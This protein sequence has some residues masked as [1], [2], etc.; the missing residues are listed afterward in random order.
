V[1]AR[2]RGQVLVIFAGGLVAL[3]AI[4]ALVIDLGF[5]FMIRRQEQNA[6]DPGAVAAARFIR[7]SATPDLVG[8][9]RAACFYARTNGFFR[10]ATT[11]DGCIP[12]N[13]DHGT[14]LTVN[15]PPSSSGGTYAGRTGFVEVVLA[16]QHQTFLGRVIG[17]S[18]IGVATSAVGAYS[19]GDSNTSSL[20]A[21]DP[22]GSCGSTTGGRTHGTGD[23]LIH[24]V[25][26]VTSGGYVHVNSTCGTATKDTLCLNDSQGALTVGGTS[27]LT[28]PHT[29][30]SGTCKSN[31]SGLFGTLTEGAVQIGDPLLELPPPRLSDY[32]AGQCGPTGIVT[33]PTGPN[34]GGCVFKDD[35]VVPL[36][37]GV[38]Y[39]G[40]NIQ[41][42]G[43]T[44]ELAPG[45]YILA[46]GGIKLT[47]G[48]SI[49][50]VQGGGV[51]VPAPVMIFNTD[52]PATNSGQANID[53]NATATLALRALDSGPY[54]GIVVWNDGNGSNPG[55]LID[56]KGQSSLN[57]SG[58]IYSPKGHVN[59]EGGSSGTS[60]ASVQIISWTW[61]IGGNA[62]LDMPYDPSKL[63][64]FDQKG[65]V[66]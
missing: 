39:G 1:S 11:D 47:I 8:M 52:N 20:I 32:P 38:Y 37:P 62:D 16:R 5:V 43:A 61:D 3:L 42:N 36:S 46:G 14:T 2:Q 21:L 55:A 64:R 26:G 18:T 33:A 13:D 56:L 17:L 65:L 24:P 44:L 29:Y 25:A 27:T 57:L 51:G 6:A 40:W 30:V 48:G 4:A 35:V 31:G 45:I 7:S 34:S 22:S 53:F 15:Y 49:T 66:H 59:M 28:A 23:I 63:Y 54:R 10:A 12:A 19:D 60:T 50:S 58:T 41:K 9:R